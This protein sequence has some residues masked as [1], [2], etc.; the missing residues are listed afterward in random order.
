MYDLSPLV[1]MCFLVIRKFYHAINS[2]LY[3]Q[4]SCATDL[5][6]NFVADNETMAMANKLEPNNCRKNCS[7]LSITR[8]KY[9]LKIEIKERPILSNNCPCLKYMHNLHVAI[10][11]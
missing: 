8:Q 7:V 9:S 4:V 3:I 5:Y 6:V 10:R 2:V 1:P 11:L